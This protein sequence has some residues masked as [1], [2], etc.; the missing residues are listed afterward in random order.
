M[1]LVQENGENG[2]VVRF[3]L[4]FFFFRGG[5]VVG[6]RILTNMRK[7][8]QQNKNKKYWKILAEK[9]PGKLLERTSGVQGLSDAEKVLFWRNTPTD[10]DDQMLLI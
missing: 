8:Q 2:G 6:P 4:I 7:E 1:F 3:F 5:G 10:V 9:N